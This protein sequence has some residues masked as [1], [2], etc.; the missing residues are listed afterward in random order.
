[1][2]LR[3]FLNQGGIDKVKVIAVNWNEE[4]HGKTTDRRL[5]RMVQAFHP[6]IRVI[7][8]NKKIERD[9]APLT[10]VPTSF[11]FDKEGTVVY[12]DGKQ[13]FLGSEKLKK[14]LNS[15]K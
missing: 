14:I 5:E 6:I 7:I 4:R 11:I 13:A 12:G 1:V 15:I 8:A 2:Q 10:F 9:F 3:E